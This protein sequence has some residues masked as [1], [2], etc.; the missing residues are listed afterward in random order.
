MLIFNYFFQFYNFLKRNVFEHYNILI[1]ILSLYIYY[2]YQAFK[3]VDLDIFYISNMAKEI[4]LN[5]IYDPY[6]GMPYL[7]LPQYNNNLY[8]S[9]LVL[10]HNLIP[11]F[12]EVQTLISLIFVTGLYYFYKQFYIFLE[13]NNFIYIGNHSSSIPLILTLISMVYSPYGY[14]SL[15]QA[16]TPMY[17]GF[18]L[19]LY[20]ILYDLNNNYSNNL[21][22]F[23]IKI[24]ISI[25]ST[26][27]H[28]AF[29]FPVSIYFLSV[30]L[31]NS[32]KISIFINFKVFLIYLLPLAC[33]AL[34]YLFFNVTISGEM[35]K[36]GGFWSD[37]WIRFDNFIIVSPKIF[38]DFENLLSLFCFSL[39]L[40]LY[41][42]DKHLFKNLSKFIII[43]ILL[44][45]IIYFVPPFPSLIV[46]LI[47]EIGFF[48]IHY[49][50][51]SFLI[52]IFPLLL[53]ISLQK[54]F[55]KIKIDYFLIILIL[56][57]LFYLH[58]SISHRIYFPQ[59]YINVRAIDSFNIN[60]SIKRYCNDCIIVSDS[61]LSYNLGPFLDFKFLSIMPNRMKIQMSDKK[62]LDL[63]SYN[64]SLLE[65]PISSVKISD[66][67]YVFITRNINDINVKYNINEYNQ[68]KQIYK[69][70]L[71]TMFVIE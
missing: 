3:Y 65:N 47:T 36:P 26:L 31:H 45:S 28:P 11:N 40:Y 51:F 46:P 50:I 14:A 19:F 4:S 6:L 1:F 16:S 24:I 2:E 23:L 54:S 71:I 12:M 62:A 59:S 22:S 43:Y 35:F 9:F 41:F 44:V 34:Y 67:R 58:K 63:Y 42:I 7:I 18:L 48:R 20:L 27:V 8:F 32:N 66:T 15:T 52:V 38:N 33:V 69:D 10:I 25:F 55:K 49:P 68:M 57:F 13:K 29:I 53:I 39:F 64:N 17:V 56:I 60:K 70:F 5:G 61:T 21:S 37:N 30:C